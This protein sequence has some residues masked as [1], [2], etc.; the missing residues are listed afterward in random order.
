MTLLISHWCLEIGP[1]GSV[2]IVEISNTQLR[3]PS[4][5]GSNTPLRALDTGRAVRRRQPR[6]EACAGPGRSPGRSGRGLR[7][8]AGLEVHALG[9]AGARG[10][11]GLGLLECDSGAGP[12]VT[13]AVG[14]SREGDPSVPSLPSTVSGW[15]GQ[16]LLMTSSSR[17][18]NREEQ[19]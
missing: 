16:H 14:R 15:M 10:G 11:T 12:R 17:C 18:N 9:G 2:D 13:W 1:S 5:T 19:L 3:A 8:G 7:S 6:K 4:T